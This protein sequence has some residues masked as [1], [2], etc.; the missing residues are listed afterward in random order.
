VV[1]VDDGRVFFPDERAEE[2]V[3]HLRAHWTAHPAD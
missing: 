2:L 1:T 3:T